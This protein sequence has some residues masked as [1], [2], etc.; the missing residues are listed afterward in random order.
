[1]AE[2]SLLF[3]RGGADV[4]RSVFTRH[5]F[6]Y[7]TA[8]FEVLMEKH[9]WL[10]FATADHEILRDGKGVSPYAGLIVGWLPE[11]QWRPK[12]VET[13]RD[14]PGAMFLE[15]PL[16]AEL[17][18]LA[19][20]RRD[21]NTD[22]P[23]EAPL[24]FGP[25]SEAYIERRFGRTFHVGHRE[26]L[27]EL[28]V[29]LEPG[30][31]PLELVRKKVV[32]RPPGYSR[33]MFADLGD[34]PISDQAGTAAVSLALAYRLRFRRNGELFADPVV[35][36]LA[37][38]FCVRCVAR[39]GARPLR[40]VLR[41]TTRG[42]IDGREPLERLVDSRG[43]PLGAIWGVILAEA[44]EALE[45]EDW[46]REAVAVSQALATSAVHSG[47]AAESIAALARDW[48]AL[49]SLSLLGPGGTA[50]GGLDAGAIEPLEPPSLAGGVNPSKL[51]RIWLLESMANR[52][53]APLPSP[54]IRTSEWLAQLADDV[55]AGPDR[56]P[57]RWFDGATT[58]E[59]LLTAGTLRRAGRTDAAEALWR[60]AVGRL[61]D[62]TAASFWNC[63][64]VSGA[65]KRLGAHCVT[66]LA[67]LGM[68][69][70]TDSIVAHDA[71]DAALGSY[72]DAQVEAWA[73]S[74]YWIDPPQLVDG[75]AEVS[76]VT[77]DGDV[78]GVW[79]RGRVTATSFQLLAHLSH[80]HTMHPLDSP[81]ASHRHV[82]GMVLEYVVFKL[83]EQ[84]LT[85]PHGPHLA[86]GPWPWGH[87]Y[88]VTLRHDVDRLLTGRQFS[89]LLKL[90][91]R[92]GTATTWFWLPDRLRRRQLRRLEFAERH[93]VGLHSVRWGRKQAEHAQLRR[94]VSR[95]T[96]IVGEAYHGAGD[97]WL[98]HPSVHEAVE[99]GL[100]YTELVPTVCDL[101]YWRHP[102]LES[103][104]LIGFDPIVGI[105]YNASV[106]G[107]LG[108]LPDTQ[109]GP[110]LYRQL[111]NHPDLN[112]DRLAL[113]LDALPPGVRLNWT[114]EQVATWWMATHRR[115]ALQVSQ[116]SR[117]P[118]ELHYR[119][120][121]AAAIDDLELRL[122]VSPDR[123]I[124]IVADSDEKATALEFSRLEVPE[125][126]GIRIRA[127]IGG[128]ERLDIRVR[129]RTDLLGAAERADSAGL[130]QRHG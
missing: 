8:A 109:C 111:L 20:A 91:M 5:G 106:D 59:I 84:G 35:N 54:L 127:S 79:T 56:L 10:D 74:P 30:D 126:D 52:L 130:A 13:L 119:L 116:I 101:P 42:M 22:P 41:D 124:E 77:A 55:L 21:S 15:G 26:P 39:V 9:G 48:Q 86:V 14:Y 67:G 72:T 81:Y 90:E 71:A 19:G 34:G 108:H 44:A 63:K 1:M 12:Y 94:A 51:R 50:T 89:R 88:C 76:L 27:P 70:L 73:A 95:G 32:T 113:Q 129:T 122:N 37:V 2:P 4:M 115:E 93:E 80:L 97:S 43:S 121:A 11:P 75:C 45:R 120:I 105:T 23:D 16:P 61:Y 112:F 107:Q 57:P 66:P 85:D 28:T 49:L 92:H 40:S 83:I 6:G 7:W 87:D 62:P 100:V 24:R 46:R 36:A 68:V 25:V 118:R 123:V 31:T 114:C 53:S 60:D 82:D 125:L 96:L 104:G 78:P 33:A 103:D 102:R 117:T 64:V 47:S 98:G 99:D 3:V 128:G 17:L 69:D 58:D 65:M 38:L 18:E 29:G 110:G